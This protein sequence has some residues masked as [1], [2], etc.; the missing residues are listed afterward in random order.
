MSVGFLPA[1]VYVCLCALYV[2]DAH[3]GLKR[4][5]ESLELELLMVMS[6]HLGDGHWT[7]VVWTSPAISAAPAKHSNVW[8]SCSLSPFSRLLFTAKLSL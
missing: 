5:S 1:C 4:V 7:R 8:L 6:L 2:S 3:R